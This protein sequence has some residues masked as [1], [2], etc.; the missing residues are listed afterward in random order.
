MAQFPLNKI[1]YSVRASQAVTQYGVGAMVDFP[2]QTLM[3]AAPEYWEKTTEI[4]DERLEKILHVNNFCIPEKIS[5]VRFPEWYFCPKCRRFQPISEWI[6]EYKR[7]DKKHQDSDP[8]M[9]N[10]LQC[11]VCHQDLVVTRARSIGG[12]KRICNS[13]KLKFKTGASASEGLE[14]LEIT[15]DTCGAKATLR[16]AFDPDIFQKLQEKTGYDFTCTGHHPWK[17][18]HDNC[19]KFPKATQRGSSSVYFPVVLSSIVI[20]PYSSKLTEKIEKNKAYN[21]FITQVK[22]YMSIPSISEGQ[23][24]TLVLSAVDQNS[25][26]ICKQ[27][28]AKC[29]QVKE[30]LLRKLEDH[31]DTD[32]TF[33]SKFKYEEYCALS[34]RVSAIDDQDGDFVRETT[35]IEDYDL[36]YIKQVSL[37]NK[38]RE[39]QALIG[40]TRVHPAEK[41]ESKMTQN[42]VVSVKEDPSTSWF[43]AYQVKGEGIFIEFANDEIEKWINRNPEIRDRVDGLNKK[44]RESFFGKYSFREISPKFVLL[45]TISHLLIKRLSFECGYSI[46]SLRERIY[47][48]RDGDADNM[49]G[50][51]IY[52]ASGDSEGTLGGL[53]RQGRPD[54]FPNIFKRAILEAKT[55]SND[56]VC[57]L[58]MGQGRESL[59]L[60]ACYSCTLIPETSCEEFNIFLDRCMVVG[61]LDQPNIGFYSKQINEAEPWRGTENNTEAHNTNED[62]DEEGK[63]SITL[64]DFSTDCKDMAYS[65]IWNNLFE[66]ANETETKLL[67]KFQSK[68]SLFEKKEKPKS[69]CKFTIGSDRSKYTCDLMWSESKV[70][71]F[72]ENYEDSYN[73]AKDTSWH[74]FYSSDAAFDVD[75]FA[76]LLKKG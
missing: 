53:V 8:Y 22:T 44:Y 38:V 68:I 1:N 33:S 62:Q 23:K 51:F 5:Y 6:A 49:S 20:P 12:A 25:N 55:C 71:L 61:T 36:P 41:S 69:N 21:D 70:A 39:V 50:I 57:S 43:P 26:V 73:A 17:H 63:P 59:N 10:R 16:D 34:G 46:A 28:G 42:N 48:D 76:S 4:H 35:N 7:N 18:V 13:P 65:K 19:I 56:P 60:A 2:D 54:I 47:C 40:F 29:D 52:T 64:T 15:C 37:I 24:K 9:I 72:T 58:S 31:P 67:K 27:I 30:V 45:H 11:T 14:G 32:D 74:C 75:Y 66:W 3:T